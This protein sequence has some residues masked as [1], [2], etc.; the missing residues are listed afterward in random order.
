MPKIMEEQ[1]VYKERFVAVVKCNGKILRERDD[2]VTLPFGA[3]YSLLFKNLESRRAVIN[4]FIDGKDVLGGHQLVIDSNSEKEIE[5]FLDNNN[6]INGRKFKFIQKT[7]E[8]VEHRGD[9]IDDGLIRIEFRYEAKKPEVKITETIHRHR[10][11]HCYD[12]N[13]PICYP[14]YWYNDI[15]YTTSDSVVW[16][17]A[18][19]E[20]GMTAS[21]GKGFSTNINSIQ[22]ANF[23]SNQSIPTPEISQDEGITVKGSESFQ[24]F[25][26]TH[27]GR[28]EEN[29]NVIILRLRGTNSKDEIISEPITVKTKIECTT[30]GR[31]NDSAGKYC[32][33]CGTY[34][35]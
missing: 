8:I 22:T 4:I 12:Y 15:R 25:H 24:E 14:K 28:L 3:E 19:T 21:T 9:K 30:C 10:H 23:V 11:T 16:S 33:N 20:R 5:R 29:T 31:K 6:L 13:C 32:S 1:M 18:N 26:Y 35:M 27:T 17:A 2:I 7:Q 34:L